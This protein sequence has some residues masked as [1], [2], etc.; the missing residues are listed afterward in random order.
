[1]INFSRRTFFLIL[2]ALTAAVAV[3]SV[4]TV[5][6]QELLSVGDTAPAFNLPST[7][8]QTIRLSDYRHKKNL[9]IVFYP[10]DNTPGCTIQLCALRDNLAEITALDTVVLGS[11]PASVRSHE[12]FAKRQQYTFPILSDT[13]SSM[14]KSYGVN[15]LFGFNRRT[16]YIVDKEGTIQFAERGMPTVE[17][18]IKV[19]QDFSS[20]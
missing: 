11:N 17:E 13:Q 19:I 3:W 16:V 4:P 18:L 8:N 14:A 10:G 5:S 20:Q 9:I 1:M 7:G 6:A 2:V 15:G 12:A